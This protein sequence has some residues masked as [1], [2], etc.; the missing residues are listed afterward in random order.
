VLRFAF[1]P[2]LNSVV[3]TKT[4][5]VSIFLSLE[6]ELKMASKA[7]RT[8]FITL[9]VA[10]ASIESQ[11]VV[12]RAFCTGNLPA[13]PSRENFPL[14]INIY[15][16]PYLNTYRPNQLVRV[17]LRSIDP[18]FVFRGFLIQAHHPLD[19]TSVSG[20]WQT[21][22]L[23][24]AISCSHPEFEG[25]DAAAQSTI[26]DRH[27]QELIWIAPESGNYI[28]NLTTAQETGV[29]WVDQLSPVL[30]VV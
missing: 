22:S 23:G 20:R 17:T 14:A 7:L 19:P 28:L 1:I 30:R 25:D 5:S 27:Y 11:S 12:W 6:I 29:Y 13:E 8:L 24:Q 16:D 15:P 4:L 2:P 18:E 26:T 9:T 3:G 21:G 10:A